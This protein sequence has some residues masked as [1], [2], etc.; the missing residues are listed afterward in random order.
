MYVP[1]RNEEKDLDAHDYDNCSEE[2]NSQS[3]R[4][5]V[6]K[7]KLFPHKNNVEEAR[8]VV[9]EF[10]EQRPEHMGDVLDPELQKGNEEDSAEG[11]QPIDELAAREPQG[12]ADEDSKVYS[13]KTI[14]KRIDISQKGQMLKSVRGLDEDQRFAFDIIIKFIKQLRS[15]RKSGAKRP[16]PVLLKIHGGAGS[17]KSKLIN[18]IAAWVEYWMSVAS[19]KDPE[20]PS[21]V[22]ASFTGRAS[23]LIQ[24]VTLTSGFKLDWGIRH[25][26]L[27]DQTREEFRS[28]LANL[29]VLIIDEV[30]MVKSDMLY[31][32]DLRL[33]EIKQSQSMFGGVSVILVGDLMQLRPV[34]ANWIFDVPRNKEFKASHTLLPLWEQFKAIE[35]K[36]NHRQGEDKDYGDLLNRVRVGAHTQED[37]ELL[38]TRV[39]DKFPQNAL[40]VYGKRFLVKIKT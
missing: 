30:S 34:M 28:M 18:D 36:T 14:Y 20:R 39:T 21:V 5:Q 35:L 10:A 1:W 25:S 26:S 8:A 24:G 16:K 3:H 4:I 12:Q 22:K 2:F 6:I 40:Y 19:D 7:E 13:E 33:K 11:D 29:T 37:L 32:L 38:K 31:Q 23:A 27:P 17:G 9:E 15:S